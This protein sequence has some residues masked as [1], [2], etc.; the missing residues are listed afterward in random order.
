MQRGNCCTLPACCWGGCWGLHTQGCGP[1]LA[2]GP[3]V[4]AV[5][6]AGGGTLLGS[7][8]LGSCLCCRHLGDLSDHVRHQLTAAW[9]LWRTYHGPNH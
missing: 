2:A 9:L 3:G 7:H 1:L 5:A 6:A 8:D 4:G